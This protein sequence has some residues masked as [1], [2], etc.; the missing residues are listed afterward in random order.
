MYT[1]KNNYCTFIYYAAMK[2]NNIICTVKKNLFTEKKKNWPA[3]IK[4]I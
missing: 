1:E 2:L 4:K 3:V